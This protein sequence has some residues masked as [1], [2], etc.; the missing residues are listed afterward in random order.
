MK[1][2]KKTISPVSIDLGAKKTG[3]YFAHY[4]EGSSLDKIDKEG[5][6]YILEKD[7]YTLLMTNRTAKRHQR[8]GFDRRQMVKRLFKLIWENYFKLNWDKNIQ[9]TTSFIL[10]RRGFSFLTEEYNEEILSQFPEE[11]YELLPSELKIK[12]DENGKY[13]FASNLTEWTN[14][15][16]SKL[17]S[18][19][20]IINKRPNDLKKRRVFIAKTKMLKAYCDDRKREKKITKKFNLSNWILKEWKEKWKIKGL[21]NVQSNKRDV[22]L[23]DYLQKS[24][25]STV[26]KILD[27]LPDFSKEDKA[28]KKCPWHFDVAKFT[29]ENSDF[30]LPEET[31]VKKQ[32]DWKRIH[33]QHL[34]FALKKCSDELESGA[35]HRSEYFDEIKKVLENENHTHLYLKS[36]CEKLNSKGYP[37]LD[38]NKLVHLIGHLSNLELKPLRKYFNDENHKK[39]DY[40]DENRLNKI[41]SHWIINEWSINPDKDKHKSHDG[42]YSYKKLKEKWNTHEGGVIEFWMKT[43]I[44]CTIPPYQNHN[45][46]RPPKCQS[47][48]FNPE[49]L[50]V[51]YPKWVDWL[52]ELRKL[53]TVK[54]YL[55]D[56]EKNL[57]ELK[58]GKKKSYFWNETSGKLQTDSGRRTNNNLKARILQFIFDRVKVNDPLKLNE[59]YGHGKKYRQSQSSEKEKIDARNKLEKTIKESALPNKFKEHIGYQSD[60]LFKE[61]SFLHLVCKYYKKRQRAKKGRLFIHPKYR[62]VKNCGYQNTGRFDDE[63]C[64]LTYCN[65]KPRQKRYQILAD[66]ASLFQISSKKLELFVE[67][68]HGKT[69]DEKLFNWLNGIARLKAC[70]ERAAKEQKERR[71]HLKSDIQHILSKSNVKDAGSL[72]RFC[73]R[74]KNLYN[75]NF[76][77]NLYENSQKGQNDL[78]KNPSKIIYWLAQM[79]NIVFKKRSGNAKTCAVCSEDNAQRMQIAESG[80]EATKAQRLPAISTRLIDGAVMRMAR[81]V[82]SAI[83][84]DKWKKIEDD[85]KSE[86]FVCVPIITELNRFDFEPNLKEIKG[87]KIGGNTSDWDKQDSNGKDKNERIRKASLDICPYTGKRLGGNGDKDHIIPRSSKFGVL[88]DEANLIWTSTEGNMAKKN[89][90]FSLKNLNPNYKVKQFKTDDDKKIEKKIIEEIGDGQG[91][92]FKFGPYRGFIN[93][94]SEQQKFFRHA[95]FLKDNDL[96]KKVIKAINH[97]NQTLVNGTQRYFAEVLANNLYKKA[98]R[99]KKENF[100]SFDYFGVDVMSNISGKGI[101]DLRKEYESVDEKLKEYEKKNGVSQED[102]SHLI[103]AQL[104]FS[105]VADA[106]KKEGSLKLEINDSHYL[107]PIDKNTGEILQENKKYIFNEIKLLPEK[108]KS[109]QLKRHKTDK[110]FFT[111]KTLFNSNARSWHFLKLIEIKSN[112]KNIYINGHLDLETLKSCLKKEDWEIAIRDKYGY[113][114]PEKKTKKYYSYG[115]ILKQKKINDIINLYKIDEGKQYFGHKRKNSQ[116]LK[117]GGQVFTV[118]ISQIDKTKVAKFLCDHFNTLTDPIKWE[119]KNIDIYKQLEKLWYFTKSKTIDRD[120]ID[121]DISDKIKNL[122]TGGFL[123]PSLLKSWKIL[124][125]KW[126]KHKKEKGEDK[127]SD[128]LKDSFLKNQRKDHE[129]VRKSFHCQEKTLGQGFMLIKR[130]SWNKQS[131]YQC[132]SEENGHAGVGLYSQKTVKGKISDRLNPYYV[133][134]RIVLLKKLNKVKEY[135]TKE[136][137]SID[138]EKYY[139]LKVPSSLKDTISTIENKSQSKND[140]NWRIT[141]RESPSIKDLLGIMYGGYHIDELKTGKSVKEKEKIKKEA[142]IFFQIQKGTGFMTIKEAKEKLEKEKERIDKINK[143]KK[144]KIKKD[145]NFIKCWINCLKCLDEK[146]LTYK[147]SCQLKIESFEN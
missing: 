44:N 119:N 80:K 34:T 45:N 63:N 20:E 90:E 6:V 51:H 28:L 129:K 91:E 35:R 39:N 69:I 47:L 29:F 136:G 43:D 81:I 89:Q 25:V 22:G 79:N 84:N 78:N 92:R 66:L 88:N 134:E 138:E 17:S 67:D 140:S 76:V 101:Y 116:E 114:N 49:F 97:L 72:Y 60:D 5:K 117:L 11:V 7:N 113:R 115:K 123:N 73:E 77:Q 68:K 131:I 8:R 33:L 86:R 107:W 125:G 118:L 130:K 111:H 19:F 146:I 57:K 31:D 133:S 53:S 145:L 54:K 93:L 58:S 27:S 32:L 61:S 104:A 147:R 112:N 71:G 10:N 106:H 103:D 87:K 65:H 83:A 18:M 9:Q 141:F 56:F 55:D 12:K 94:T 50:Y 108:M 26:E 59:I 137:N 15:G 2:Q 14:E 127:F 42:D 128:F 23:A 135:L 3:V 110:D 16:R 99:I 36:F 75:D 100:L 30:N 143:S 102:Y 142:Q 24:D 122:E 62:Y 144:E 70:C 52:S 13:D 37:G 64:L 96:R 126:E 98:M 85:L 82:G 120:M 109:C 132:Q 1:K 121:S 4:E 38:S 124:D 74:A 40:W 105:I 41:F 139:P 21:E 48:I 46:R 95:L